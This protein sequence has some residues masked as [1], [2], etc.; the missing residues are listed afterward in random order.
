MSTRVARLGVLA[1]LPAWG[2]ARITGLAWLLAMLLVPFA[3]WIGGVPARTAVVVLAVLLLSATVTLLLVQAAGIVTALRI[4]VTIVVVAF[5]AEAVGAATDLPFGPYGYTPLLQP[6]LAGVPIVIP[7][8]W[9]MGL[10][11]AWGAAA[12]IAR[13]TAG[14]AFIVLSALAM[15]AWDLFLDPQMVHWGL[16]AWD[17]PG[18][19][20]GIPLLNFAGWLLVSALATILARPRTLPRRPLLV[21][22]TATWAI[23]MVGLAVFWGL[24][25]PAIVGALGMGIVVIAAW[26]REL[27]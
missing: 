8:A 14:P 6:Q 1:D 23:E 24:V 18:P 3:E 19:Y 26:W 9:L 21:L 2:P 25:G 12:A 20:F 11:L 15:T 13:G 27:R 7:L 17:E 5:V 16:W 4:A 22:Y 10:P